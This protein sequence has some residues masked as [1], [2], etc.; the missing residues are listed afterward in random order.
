M[1]NNLTRI[2]SNQNDLTEMEF[3]SNDLRSDA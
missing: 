3:K 2:F 1:R